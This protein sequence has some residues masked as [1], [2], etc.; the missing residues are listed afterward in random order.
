MQKNKGNVEE[1]IG[2]SP[3]QT[4]IPLEELRCGGGVEEGKNTTSREGD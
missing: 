3:T 4:F 1:K 2:D